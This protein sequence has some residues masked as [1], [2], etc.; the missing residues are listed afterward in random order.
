M[1]G[2]LVAKSWREVLGDGRRWVWL[3]KGNRKD[4][5]GNRNVIYLECG[6]ELTNLHM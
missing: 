5:Y 6:G 1:N 2:L 3:F 4:S